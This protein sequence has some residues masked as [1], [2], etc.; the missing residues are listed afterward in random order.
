[1]VYFKDLRWWLH[2]L[3]TETTVAFFLFIC[4]EWAY[5]LFPAIVFEQR[6]LYLLSGSREEERHFPEA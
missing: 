6:A 1:M 4:H 3:T 2:R 5:T